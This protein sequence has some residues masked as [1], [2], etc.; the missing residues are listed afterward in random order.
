MTNSFELVDVKGI[1]N[2]NV[3]VDVDVDTD[4]IELLS[5]VIIGNSSM[6][7]VSSVLKVHFY[8]VNVE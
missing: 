1:N 6:I 8:K 5:S 7:D 4:D 3:E 2:V